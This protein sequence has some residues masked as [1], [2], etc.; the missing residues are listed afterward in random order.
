MIN[1][2]TVNNMNEATRLGERIKPSN[3]TNDNPNYA[4]FEKTSYPLVQ[5]IDG[6]ECHCK[7]S[8]LRLNNVLTDF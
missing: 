5:M 3:G 2:L 1:Q 7:N 4:Y 8:P 6:V